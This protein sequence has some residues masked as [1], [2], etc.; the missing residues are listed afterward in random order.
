MSEPTGLPLLTERLVIRPYQ[1]EDA[2]VFTA[3]RNDPEVAR[4]QAWSLPFALTK[5]EEHI[6]SFVALGGPTAG[7]WYQLAVCDRATGMLIGDLPVLVHESFPTAEIGYSF[8]PAWQGRGLATEAA[9]ALVDWLFDRYGLRRLEA[10][11]DPANLPSARLLER[12]GFLYEGTKRLGYGTH[13]NPSDDPFYGLLRSDWEAWKVRPRQSPEQVWLIEITPD[14][15]AAV[16]RVTIPRSQECT[17]TPLP[18][19]FIE[20]VVPP[21]MDGAPIAPWYRA[22]EADGEIVG[23]VLMS[24]VTAAHP[25][26]VLRILLIDRWH[27][28]RGI[29]DLVR[30]Q[31]PRHVDLSSA[32]G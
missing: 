24:D 23:F 25:A 10:S 7:E 28:G 16:L 5:A 14:N 22:V 15:I 26:P 11:L 20:A 30:A 9:T 27:Q 13:D 4:Y 8:A 21:V 19:A 1:P 12:L 2:V 31:L 29:A 6:A 17:V 18:T 32:Q 3:I